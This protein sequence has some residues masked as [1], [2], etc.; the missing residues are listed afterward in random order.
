MRVAT[1][2]GDVYDPNPFARIFGLTIKPK[3]GYR[4]GVLYGR[5]APL[6]AS[7]RTNLPAYD[8]TFNG[9]LAP[10]LEVYTQQ[11]L[12]DPKFQKANLTMKREMLKK[13]MSDVKSVIRERMEKGFSGE[14]GVPRKAAQASSKYSK[15][16]RREALEMMK[17]SYEQQAP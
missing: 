10:L 17:E 16:I 14:R 12:D 8:K 9:L 6:K 11:L 5:D 13:R 4:K 7:E 3:N 15:E 2:E 1:R